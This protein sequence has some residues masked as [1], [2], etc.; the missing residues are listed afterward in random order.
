L[1]INRAGRDPKGRRGFGHRHAG[2]ITKVHNSGQVRVFLAEFRQRLVHGKD[3][4][5]RS[6]VSNL[7]FVPRGPRL[8]AT[9]LE[10]L[11]SA[12]AIN[13]NPSHRLGC[14]REEMAPAI[15]VLVVRLVLAHEPKISFVDEGRGLK[16]MPGPLSHHLMRRQ[17]AQFGIDQG[18]KFLR[19]VFGSFSAFGGSRDFGDFIHRLAKLGCP[20]DSKKS[21]NRSHGR[22]F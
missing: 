6:G 2:E 5:R 10:T 1:P 14:R 15:P 18:E 21:P 20:F 7:G 17:P 13:Q 19:H 8:I 4:F 22:A 16:G 3:L 9:T 12:G 11:L